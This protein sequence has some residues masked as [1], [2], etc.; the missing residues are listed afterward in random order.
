MPVPQ[1]SPLIDLQVFSSD[2]YNET[3]CTI[4]DIMA[5]SLEGYNQLT[6][7]PGEADITNFLVMDISLLHN[8]INST[9][10]SKIYVDIKPGTNYT[11][12][13]SEIYQ[14]AP[15]SFNQIDS[16]LP[17]IK[18][19]LDSRATQSVFGAYTLN[20][21]FSLIYLSF[22]MV[23][24]TI[25]RVRNLRKQFSVIRAIGADS[26][27]MLLASLMDTLI[28]VS[29]A[30]LIGGSIGCILAFLLK[31]IPLLYMGLSTMQIWAR[32]PVNL[33][34]PWLLL[35]G[36]IGVAVSVSILATYVV[37]SRAL[38]LNIAEEIQYTG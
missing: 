7:F 21:I 36:I 5:S 20:V 3:E 11:K 17:H 4:V 24:V 37:V 19:V 31:N 26:K 16:P 12:A 22:G 28:G 25:V 15:Y 32:L 14:I 18:E 13:M 1:Y 10:V 6:Y 27:S 30:A 23:I 8:W 33:I 34:V 9:R 29:I 35:I 38:N 2:W